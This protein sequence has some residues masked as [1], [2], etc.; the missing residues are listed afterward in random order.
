M[1]TN[2]F[3]LAD[4]QVPIKLTSAYK[5]AVRDKPVTYAISRVLAAIHRLIDE[6]G[7]HTERQNAIHESLTSGS[8]VVE[9]LREREADIMS[10]IEAVQLEKQVYGKR[11]I[12]RMAEVQPI[13]NQCAIESGRLSDEIAVLQRYIFGFA[14]QREEAKE[15]YKRA[16]LT[17]EKIAGIG[18]L[19]SFEN[20][21]DWKTQLAEKLARS[22]QITSFYRS[23]P[24]YD[25]SLLAVTVSTQAE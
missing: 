15:K 14:K 13:L 24:E 5:E 12:A 4:S 1:N 3:W 19:P 10:Q 22:E 20:L 9:R 18:I 25:I 7:F 17:E 8:S 2:P 6:S 23:S 11:G 21:A 16:C